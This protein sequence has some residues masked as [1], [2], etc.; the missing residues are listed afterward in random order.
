MDN[1]KKKP[2]KNSDVENSTEKLKQCENRWQA[3]QKNGGGGKQP[4]TEERKEVTKTPSSR[5]R[6]E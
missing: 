5:R 4:G 1:E 6:R 3:G 2:R